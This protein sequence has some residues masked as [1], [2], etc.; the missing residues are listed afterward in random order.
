MTEKCEF[1]KTAYIWKLFYVSKN[2]VYSFDIFSVLSL[3][4][5]HFKENKGAF[6]YDWLIFF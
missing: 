3:Y 5:Q 1:S 4:V 6:N 2:S